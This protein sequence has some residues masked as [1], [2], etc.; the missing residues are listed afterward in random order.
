MFPSV[1][2]QAFM[3][4][5]LYRVFFH[6]AQMSFILKES[7]KHFFPSDVHQWLQILVCIHLNLKGTSAISEPRGK[8]MG[9]RNFYQR[10]FFF[11][12]NELMQ[13]RKKRKRNGLIKTFVILF[14][15]VFLSL[16]IFQLLFI[17]DVFWC[18]SLFCMLHFINSVNNMLR[19]HLL[20]VQNTF[21][22][23]DNG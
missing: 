23:Q 15:H 9:M 8:L 18:M 21:T 14:R 12:M 19:V 6:A 4:H 22:S 20:P 3:L 2:K 16:C 10:A 7:S 1:C 17:D 13:E 11:L 5:V